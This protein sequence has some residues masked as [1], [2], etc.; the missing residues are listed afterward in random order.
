MEA[1]KNRSRSLILTNNKHYEVSILIA[2][3]V[4]S[5]FIGSYYVLLKP[6]EKKYTTIYLLNS[7]EQAKDYPEILI[8][9]QNSTFNVFLEVENH[10]GA[11]KNCTVLEKITSEM[12]HNLPL[13]VDADATYSRVLDNGE[14][15]SIPSSTTIHQSGTYSVI[16][17]LWIYDE[18]SG[19]LQFSGN[20]CSLNLV[21]ADAN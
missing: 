17:E 19:K 4:V 6:P 21:V 14:K 20:A 9:N 10:M 16:F 3:I 8:I 2:L 13:M 18:G 7:Q 11:T 1:F 15:W 5:V 12:I